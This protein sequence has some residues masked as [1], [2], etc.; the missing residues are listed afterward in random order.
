MQNGEIW[1]V[2]I[3]EVNTTVKCARYAFDFLLVTSV[4]F[5]LSLTA[6]PTLRSTGCKDVRRSM[7]VTGH[8][9][10]KKIKVLILI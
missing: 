1:W 4:V 3:A 2:K 5:K 9:K 10:L 6:L 7:G 8:C